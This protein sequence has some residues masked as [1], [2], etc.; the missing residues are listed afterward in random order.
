MQNRPLS[1]RSLRSYL[2]GLLRPPRGPASGPRQLAGELRAQRQLRADRI[3]QRLAQGKR[4]L[5]GADLR[6]LDLRDIDLAGCDLRSTDLSGAILENACLDRVRCG[7]LLRWRCVRGLLQM[8]LGL[9]AGGL[10][11]SAAA[12]C[13]AE[14]CVAEVI[15]QGPRLRYV[16]GLLGTL[17]HGLAL[18][19]FLRRGIAP[20][21]VLMLALLA[22]LGVG[23][24]ALGL[25]E[26][27]ESVALGVLGGSVVLAFALAWPLAAAAGLVMSGIGGTAAVGFAVFAAV[28]EHGAGIPVA[29][30]GFG[31]LSVLLIMVRR[32]M[33]GDPR[34]V[35]QRALFLYIDTLFGTR[36]RGSDLLAASFAGADLRHA[37]FVGAA[38]AG[39]RLRGA[40]HA[41]KARFA[42]GTLAQPQV[43]RLLTQGTGQD[44]YFAHL[45]L[46]ELVIRGAELRG[47]DFTQADL[48]GTDLTGSDL[49][50]AAELTSARIDASTCQRS[51]WRPAYLQSLQSRGVQLVSV[52]RAADAMP[53]LKQGA[54]P[55]LLLAFA[56]GLD[57]LEQLLVRA[58]IVQELGP[59][60]RCRVLLP[61]AA[62]P[63]GSQLYI[64][65][66][67]RDE[68]LHLLERLRGDPQRQRA[69][70]PPAGPPSP[71]FDALL[72]PLVRRYDEI[73]A[74]HL[75][76]IELHTALPGAAAGTP[77][78]RS[79]TR[80]S[81]AWDVPGGRIELTRP[82][83]LAIL[84]AGAD[85]AHAE[86]LRRRLTSLSALG[87][88]EPLPAPGPASRAAVARAD[89][90][91][92]LLSPDL[93]A[94]TSAQGGASPM[95]MPMSTA[96]RT[97]LTE[98]LQVA[99]FRKV[100]MSVLLRA[101]EG[102]GEPLL[103]LPRLP[104]EGQP[105]TGCADYEA[106]LRD[107]VASVRWRLLQLLGDETPK[108]DGPTVSS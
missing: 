24:G 39:C 72:S 47:A 94:A 105:L 85:S 29:A 10:L 44:G 7:V 42:A 77:A 9:L 16:P 18:W 65:S 28:Q 100:A 21:R 48:R 104:A 91:L 33:A 36:F 53:D 66:A 38:L 76:R 102:A 97:A 103:E 46:R 86:A 12:C 95:T 25:P 41:D 45:N 73:A 99:Q 26:L 60:T 82:R 106:A 98:S 70:P 80:R 107:V 69:L 32:A 68:L 96:E 27:A 90:V 31:L 101:V 20:K 11:A 62:N 79:P 19:I 22:G 83:R 78:D 108:A 35:R 61:E 5:R 81:L 37:D 17:A 23:I 43:L 34:H 30:F 67:E 89:L 50:Q 54:G 49:L 92:F 58:V 55:G 2:S 52:G 75:Q 15:A 3:R 93:L 88:M 51:G 59:K 8:L 6:L 56:G 4:D 87:L 40:R 63:P 14:F 84:H 57:A 1:E 64:Q 71:A 74:T 13:A